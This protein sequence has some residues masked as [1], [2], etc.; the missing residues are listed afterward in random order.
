[1]RRRRTRPSRRVSRMAG[2]AAGSRAAGAVPTT[3]DARGSGWAR[4]TCGR[5]AGSGRQRGA[6]GAF[7]LLRGLGRGRSARSRNLYSPAQP[8]VRREPSSRPSL[9]GPGEPV[10][11]LRSSAPF[12][13]PFCSG[14]SDLGRRRLELARDISKP[15]LGAS[16]P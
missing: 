9:R 7:P 10:T 8:G 6:G 13:A 12:H 1:M 11:R 3:P 4:L 14:L 15:S 5:G 2:D 16:L